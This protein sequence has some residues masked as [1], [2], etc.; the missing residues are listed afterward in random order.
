MR[1]K[2]RPC[3]TQ[4][5]KRLKLPWIME[6][7]IFS[8]F[9]ITLEMV[10]KWCS[11]NEKSI[12]PV[13][14]WI[15]HFE[16]QPRRIQALLLFSKADYCRHQESQQLKCRR[17]VQFRIQ[18][19]RQNWSQKFHR[20]FRWQIN[21]SDSVYYLS[22]YKFACKMSTYHFTERRMYY[23]MYYTMHYTIHR[24]KLEFSR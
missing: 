21:N 8:I 22:T 1:H 13:W 23:T 10:F 9:A 6:I 5:S 24:N 11:T 3:A 4:L 18:V 17:K 14:Y 7:K 19:S 16:N 12:L 2:Q 20:K 15:H